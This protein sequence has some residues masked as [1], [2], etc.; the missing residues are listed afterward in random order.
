MGDPF[1]C[2]R[3][4]LNILRLLS[5]AVGSVKLTTAVATLMSVFCEMLA[6]GETT[7]GSTSLTV[8]EKMLLA[9][10]SRRRR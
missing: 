4:T 9:L 5:V 3:V 1:G 8:T 2:V 10:F 7:G 6:V